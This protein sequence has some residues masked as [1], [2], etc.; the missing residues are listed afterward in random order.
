MEEG[1]THFYHN[2]K[3]LFIE[4]LIRTFLC[5]LIIVNIDGFL[6]L[7]VTPAL[8]A[9]G[10][11]AVVAPVTFFMGQALQPIIHSICFFH[12]D[13]RFVMASMEA[14]GSKERLVTGLGMDK[15]GRMGLREKII[16]RY[17]VMKVFAGFF[18][19]FASIFAYIPILGPILVALTGG[20]AMAW[21]MVYVPLSCMGYHGVLQQGKSVLSR[22]NFRKYYW[23]GFWAVLMEEIPIVGPTCHVYNVYRAAAFLEIVYLDGNKAAAGNDKGK[24]QS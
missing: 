18:V 23:F 2:R 14:C 20:W 11:G 10:I 9:T 7:F 12:F 5:T 16:M 21:D 15:W 19:G 24:K 3:A 6:K 8:V 4:M 13:D 22:D 1:I 17:G